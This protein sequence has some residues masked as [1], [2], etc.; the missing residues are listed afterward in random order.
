MKKWEEG[1]NVKT[2][3]ERE[4]AENRRKEGGRIMYPHREVFFVHSGSA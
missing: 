2:N 1:P 3:S 4:P